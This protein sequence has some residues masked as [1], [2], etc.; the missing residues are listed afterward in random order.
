MYHIK[1][2]KLKHKNNQASL[3]KKED[4]DLKH[5]ND[6][7]KKNGNDEN[8]DDDD[9]DEDD[10]DLTKQHDGYRIVIIIALFIHDI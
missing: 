8:D 5:G 3:D 7:M 1:T 4:K 9:D 10:E 6:E 2:G